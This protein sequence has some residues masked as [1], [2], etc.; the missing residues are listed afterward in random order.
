MKKKNIK[1][2]CL[3]VEW[4][5]HPQC[6]TCAVRNSL[7]FSDIP[8]EILNPFLISVDNYHFHPRAHLYEKGNAGSDLFS[9]RSGIVKLEQSMPNGALRVVRLL[10]V[11]DVVGLEALTG[12]HYHHSA[13]ALN[14]V[15]ACRIPMQ[16]IR[17]LNKHSPKLHMQLM[18]RL[19]K[20][21]DEADDFI[22]QLSTGGATARL[23]RLL[24]KLS[25]SADHEPFLAPSREDIGA[26]LGVTTETAS[27]VMAEF[28]RQG[29]L[30]EVHGQ[31]VSCDCSQLA[32][33]AMDLG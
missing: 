16:V 24:L 25:A 15:D 8:D 23:A 7:L 14:E 6:N 1:A 2:A 13:V 19:Q 29:W 22:L 5:G 18:L 21:L 20:S 30:R 26:M 11:G 32:R 10:H 33:L 12:E 4:I 17:D 3:D 31:C 28:K 9:I 27:R